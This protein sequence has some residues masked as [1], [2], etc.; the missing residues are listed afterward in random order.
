MTRRRLRLDE[1]AAMSVSSFHRHF[2]G[3]TSMTPTQFQ[4]QIRRH[5]ARARLFA[6]PDRITGV[7]FAVGYASPRSSAANTGACSACLPA[8]TRSHCAGPPRS[9]RFRRANAYERAAG[10]PQPADSAGH[11]A[12]SHSSGPTMNRPGGGE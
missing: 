12:G 10:C 8:V 2:R 4:K 1:L 11:A 7:G 6:Q 9:R 3:V 5:E